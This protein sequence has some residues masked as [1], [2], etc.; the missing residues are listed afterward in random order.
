[1][2]T[3]KTLKTLLRV[4]TLA[5]ITS[6]IQAQTQPD[7]LTIKLQQAFTHESLPGM[8]VIMTDGNKV[9]YSHSFGYADEANQVPYLANTI[10]NIGSVS[11]TVIAVALMKAIELKYFTLETDINDV[12][13]FKVTNPNDPNGKITIRQLTNHT[14]GI[15]DNPEVY[16]YC[17]HFY[18]KLRAY[19]SVSIKTL[20]Q[21]GFG[22]K[23]K[24]TTLAQFFYNYLSPQGEYY[25][26]ANFGEGPA[27]S[28]SSYSNIGSALAAYLIELKSGLS[29][30]E[31]T[32]K[33]ILKPLKM[34][35]S[36]WHIEDVDL[37]K[38]AYLYLDQKNR[39]PLYDLVT[40]PD[41]GLKTSPEDLSKYLVAIARHDK[42]LLT[43]AS[44]QTM[45]TAQF[46]KEH[47]PKNINL[48]YRNK[49][50]F[51]NLYTNGTVGHDGDDPG[52]GTYLFFNTTT[53]KGGLFLCNKYLPNKQAI[54]D[55]LVKEA[56]GR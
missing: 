9:S 23:L 25:S 3:Y 38:H 8:Y 47:P 2:K 50:I 20:N 15:V 48:T 21:M 24:D 27:G 35:H 26:K 10:Q 22:D 5:L 34:D 18:P 46:N 51:W 42:K 19:D 4:L 49:G 1:M 7:S 36:G 54:V 33:Y 32:K 16:H 30:A 13:P 11:K 52:V 37:K 43:E 28:V 53:G 31:F 56:A 6:G 14:S 12:L 41:G 17:Y 29:Y 39:F 44:Y 40:Y 45:F 55:V